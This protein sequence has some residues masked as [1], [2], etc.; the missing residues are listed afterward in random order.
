VQW[1]DNK[2]AYFTSA[3]RKINVAILERS[4]FVGTSA[5]PTK[6]KAINE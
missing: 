4:N 3:I 6:V 2:P 1:G 5:F